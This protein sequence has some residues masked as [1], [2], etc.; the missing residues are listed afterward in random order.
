ME[1]DQKVTNSG[2]R[3]AQKSTETCIDTTEFPTRASTWEQVT[4]IDQEL[5]D[6]ENEITE[7]DKSDDRDNYSKKC[8]LEDDAQE[9]HDQMCALRRHYNRQPS[10]T[11]H[12]QPLVLT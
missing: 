3:I 6:L 8:D 7:L 11:N 2:F 1:I 10:E 12:E 9:L 5:C 4:F